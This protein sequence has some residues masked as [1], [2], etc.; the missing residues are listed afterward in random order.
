ML[1]HSRSHN[2]FT[3]IT[4]PSR[5][6]DKRECVKNT[7]HPQSSTNSHLALFTRYD[8]SDLHYLFNSVGL[9]RIKY[10]KRIHVTFASYTT[11]LNLKKKKIDTKILKFGD[12][13]F[14]RKRDFHRDVNGE[15]SKKSLE[16]NSSFHIKRFLS[17]E[18]GE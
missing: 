10:T 7:V 2:F 11:E 6:P 1:R 4:D 13:F 12:E 17:S 3:L 14:F 18:S 9:T 16:A 5:P 15:T 8:N